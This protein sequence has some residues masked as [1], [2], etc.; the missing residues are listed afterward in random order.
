METG[1]AFLRYATLG[2]GAVVAT[3]NFPAFAA[4]PPSPIEAVAVACRRLAP[5]GWRQLLL[6]RR[7]GLAAVVYFAPESDPLLWQL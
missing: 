6:E 1:R 4:P 7:C 5:L 3:P 2:V